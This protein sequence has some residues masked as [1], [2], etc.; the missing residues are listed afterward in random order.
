MSKSSVFLN[1]E[2]NV[3]DYSTIKPIKDTTNKG[4]R[5]EG[6]GETTLNLYSAAVSQVP[7][8]AGQIKSL[9]FKFILNNMANTPILKIKTKPKGDGSDYNPNYH[10]MQTFKVLNAGNSLFTEQEQINF[11]YKEQSEGI[12]NEKSFKFELTATNGTHDPNLEIYQIQLYGNKLNIVLQEFFIEDTHA[13]LIQTAEFAINK[14]T[15]I[16]HNIINWDPVLAWANIGSS[17]DTNNYD[18]ITIF[19]GASNNH[20]L[21]IFTSRVDDYFIYHST[22]YPTNING[23]QSYYVVLTDALRYIQLK[24]HNTT[25]TYLLSSVLK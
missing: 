18:S 25:N 12:R 22:I 6:D 5:F 2:S 4:W 1:L 11:Y 10:D 8:R 16:E 19:G 21:D 9:Y 13:K 15:P 20:P 23:V 14:N 24:N 17:I 7:I 3:Y